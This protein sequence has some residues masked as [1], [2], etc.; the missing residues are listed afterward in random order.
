MKPTG[1]FL[2]RISLA[3]AAGL[4]LAVVLVTG[5]GPAQPPPKPAVKPTAATGSDKTNTAGIMQTNAL[6]AEYVSIFEDKLPPDKGKDP[7][8]PNSHRRDPVAVV[9]TSKPKAHEVPVL[10][11]KA[12]T[13]SNNRRFAVINS[14]TF[15]LGETSSVRI[16]SGGHV[17]VTCMEI[18]E[19]YVTISV[20][21]ETGSKRLILGH[22][23]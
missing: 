7:F 21:G 11:L 12:V 18:G 6:P 9:A 19:D 8:F 4:L 17:R 14:E 20:E 5:C 23:K 2:N 10:V 1:T 22:Q 15:E 16:P 3:I 13:G